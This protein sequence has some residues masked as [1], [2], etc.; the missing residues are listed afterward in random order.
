MKNLLRFAMV[1]AVLPIAISRSDSVIE[2]E[3][4]GDPIPVDLLVGKE[5]RITVKGADELRIGIPPSLYEIF[6]AQSIK[7]S[8]W[9]RSDTPIESARVI[10]GVIPTGEFVVAEVTAAEGTAPPPDLVITIKPPALTSATTQG[11]LRQTGYAELTRWTIQQLY[12]PERLR[13]PL[14]GVTEDSVSNKPMKLFRC[15]PSVPSACGGSVES[16]AVAVWRSQNH[17]VLAVHLENTTDV[18]IVL[19]PRDL[20]GRWR[21]AAFVHSRLMPAPHPHSTTILVLISD[22]PPAEAVME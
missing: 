18:P 22:L 11:R 2:Y 16:T 19:D 12:S 5:R 3:W 13:Q 14:A 20:R 6:T 8:T 4:S 15:G 7:E 21:T 9:W 10:I 1:I 17:Y